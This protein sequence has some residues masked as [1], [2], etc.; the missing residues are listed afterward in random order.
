[1][2]KSRSFW[3]SDAEWLA[4]KDEADKLGI[5]VSDLVRKKSTTDIENSDLL[6]N[7]NADAEIK[8]DEVIWK[9]LRN[10]H[11]VIQIEESKLNI[12][13]K[14]RVLAYH[15]TFGSLPSQQA[16]R[17]IHSGIKN[18]QPIEIYSA[19]SKENENYDIPK[20]L[21]AS[22]KSYLSKHYCEVK[23]E[24]ITLDRYKNIFCVHCGVT[25]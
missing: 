16:N 20:Y 18:P 5:S 4:L 9:K 11:K 10:T 24:E 23:K 21:E 3:C 12:E 8:K 22:K 17:A 6:E 14:Q 13:I 15:E 25:I 1:L 19:Y 7:Q 2:K